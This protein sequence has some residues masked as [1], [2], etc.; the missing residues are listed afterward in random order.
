MRFVAALIVSLAVAGHARAD[1]PLTL[2]EAL[3][4]ARANNR[5]LA[6]A[7][8][9]IAQAS[10]DVGRARALLL[11]SVALQGRYTRNDREA[12]FDLGGFAVTLQEREQLDGSATLTVPLLV[13][14]AYP[15]LSAAKRGREA[16]EASFEATSSELLLG[17]AQ[18]YYAAAGADELLAARKNAVE[19]TARTLRDARTRLAAGAASQVDVTRAELATVQAEQAVTEAAG[20]RDAAYRGLAT[21]ILLRE[22]FTVAPGTRA[23]PAPASAQEL[24]A[25]A[26]RTK[27]EL[28]A[29]ER[30]VS[31]L[32]AQL[33]SNAWSW[34]PT[35]AAFATARQSSVAGMTGEKE[36]W[37]AGIQLDW[38]LFDGGTR[39]ADRSD[40]QSQRRAA[41]TQL[42]RER[43]ALADEIADRARAVETKKSAL[44]A[45]ERGLALAEETLATVRVQYAAGAVTQIELLQAQDARVASEVS[46]AQARFD[47]AMADLSL[48][49]SAGLFPDREA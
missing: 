20:A 4:L 41:D 44:A 16:S 8:E 28:R 21:L 10:A 46:L 6:I 24:T 5:D 2:E 7:R 27:P 12:G 29:L 30:S 25:A 35:V 22:P 15:A 33:A 36:A 3:R 43:D 14:P 47:L 34:A 32:D 38:K 17:V 39:S 31:A 42:A 18:A 26:L 40:L 49:Q 9:S 13:A 1:A 19:V 23:A 48:Q 37:L 45:A 11:P